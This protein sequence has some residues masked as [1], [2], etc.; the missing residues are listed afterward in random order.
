MDTKTIKESIRNMMQRE[1]VLIDF[2]NTYQ[3]TAGF[4][5]ESLENGR[6][7]PICFMVVVKSKNMF[8]H[9]IL[10]K[11]ECT[12]LSKCCVNVKDHC[13]PAIVT[14]RFE[15]YFIPHKYR[16]FLQSEFMDLIKD[17]FINIIVCN[18]GDEEKAKIYT[19]I[20]RF[21]GLNCL[22]PTNNEV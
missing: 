12:D 19:E 2:T 6:H 10:S 18:D 15:Q 3:T 17:P 22:Y 4:Y 1:L 21:A 16:A 5:P 9:R 20:L 11:I 14:N 7:T 8:V 13:N